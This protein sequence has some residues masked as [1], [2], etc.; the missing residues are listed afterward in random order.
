[1]GAPPPGVIDDQY[2][3]APVSTSPLANINPA[4]DRARRRDAFT[5]A[6]FAEEPRPVTHTFAPPFKALLWQV[7]TETFAPRSQ[8]RASSRLDFMLRRC[9]ERPQGPPPRRIAYK[10]CTK[11]VLLNTHCDAAITITGCVAEGC[12]LSP[13]TKRDINGTVPFPMLLHPEECAVLST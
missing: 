9:M 8:S 12:G 2:D 10:F 1:M 6:S 7:V 5:R 13:A 4:L 11:N 3:E